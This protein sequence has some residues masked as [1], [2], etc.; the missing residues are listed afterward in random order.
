MTFATDIAN[1][2]EVFDGTETVTYSNVAN[3]AVS[4]TDATVPGALRRNVQKS[5][6]GGELALTPQ[7]LVWHLPVATLTGTPKVGD[8]IT[9]SGSVVW[10][11][12]AVSK[13]TL[14]TRWR[15]ITRQQR[16]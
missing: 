5:Q 7:D 6:L 16:T 15:C 4:S 3:G 11:M 13:D 10:N 1:D 12:L 9:D 8:T 14:G 2:Y